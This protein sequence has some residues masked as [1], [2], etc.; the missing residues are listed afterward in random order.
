M[1]FMQDRMIVLRRLLTG[2]A[3]SLAILWMSSVAT[4]E[5]SGTVGV[6]MP[7]ASD[8]SYVPDPELEGRL[9]IAGSDTM[10]PLLTRLVGDFLRKHP[11]VKI[12]IEGGGSAPGIRKFIIG[13]SSQ[14]RG[15]KNRGATGYEGAAQ[16]TVLATSRGLTR[17]ERDNF[18]SRYGYEPLTIPI[19]LDAV[20]IYVHTSN[21]LTRLT[22]GQVDSIFS[23]TRNRGGQDI[24]TWEQVGLDGTWSGQGIRLYGR[25]RK[26]GTRDFFQTV[27]LDGGVLKESITEAPG[28]ANE[29]LAI[30]RDPLGIGYLGVGYE[31]S[32][33]RI[34]P[35]TVEGVGEGVYPTSESVA[36]GNYPLSRPL[37]LYVN[38]DPN[39]EFESVLLAFLRYINSPRG[40]S[41]VASAKAYPLT[42]VLVAKNA[43]LL[44]GPSLA[45]ATD[46]VTGVRSN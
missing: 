32:G 14:R 35:L 12:S 5:H 18:V 16:V 46:P 26:S 23:S 3:V 27:A 11:K 2:L 33:V 15:D 20:A 8:V 24:T 43:Q 4:A 6:L 41:I 28:S 39:A 36:R 1:V 42:Q 40:Q 10:R 17:A 34:V 29:V 31:V 19:A 38:Q 45:A 44:K 9:A 37:Y 30:A 13:T 7:L 25:D 22:L 21:P